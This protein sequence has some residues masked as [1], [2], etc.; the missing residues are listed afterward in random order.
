MWKAFLAQL[1]V[2]V[3]VMVFPFLCFHVACFMLLVDVE[4]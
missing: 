4:L 1:Y 3:P 2:Y